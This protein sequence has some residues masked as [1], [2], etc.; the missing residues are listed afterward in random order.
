MDQGTFYFS[1]TA[2]SQPDLISESFFSF[3]AAAQQTKKS[4]T[5]SFISRK[6]I[7]FYI[8]NLFQNK[9]I[10]DEYDFYKETNINKIKLFLENFLN[11][12]SKPPSYGSRETFGF[13]PERV[14]TYG[15][16]YKSNESK[17]V[18][19]EMVN[20]QLN[21]LKS[22]LKHFTKSLSEINHAELEYMESIE[23]TNLSRITQKYKVNKQVL[24]QES[25]NLIVFTNNLIQY[26]EMLNLNISETPKRPEN[27]TAFSVTDLET[28]ED[29][30]MQD[31]MT[32]TVPS[33]PKQ[34][35]EK[36]IMSKDT[37]GYVI[38]I[39]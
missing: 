13:H 26:L 37:S 38:F 35:A 31:K 6:P 4:I 16:N 1:Q 27:T 29:L 18:S 32:Q 15:S 33:P 3:T 2:M 22:C 28:K 23:K 39:E 7:E 34:K 12:L 10:M 8:K 30:K 5:N 9:N 17:G 36:S 24:F 21:E 14:N 20:E 11:E 25:E 19:I